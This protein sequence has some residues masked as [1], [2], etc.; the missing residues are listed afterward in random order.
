VRLLLAGLRADGSPWSVEET[1]AAGGGAAAWGPGAAGVSA[2]LD[3]ARNLPA[4]TL[5]ERAPVRVLQLGVRRGSGGAGRHRGGDGVVRAYRLLEGRAVVDYAGGRHQVPAPGEAGGQPGRLAEA[6]LER[7]DGTV[8][9][10]PARA[11]VAWQAG[12]VLVIATAGAGGWGEA[13]PG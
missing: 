5:E 2:D 11:R 1:I 3:N 7:S 13:P 8:E 6:R 9:H 12:D 4:E 10:L